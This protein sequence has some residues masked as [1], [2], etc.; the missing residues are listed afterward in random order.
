MITACDMYRFL[1]QKR[2]AL[3]KLPI[4]LVVK[5]IPVCQNYDGGTVQGRLE[6]MGIEHHREGLSTAL[7]MPKHP[8]LSIDVRWPWTQLPS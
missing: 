6:Q 4:E 1:T 2:F 3:G 8:A 5:I 7:G